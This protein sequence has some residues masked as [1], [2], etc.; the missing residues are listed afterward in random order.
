MI[1]IVSLLAIFLKSCVKS[2]TGC[3]R[4][5]SNYAPRG[6]VPRASARACGA[7]RAQPHSALTG[8]KG[9]RGS[10]RRPVRSGKRRGA[11]PASPAP[12]PLCQQVLLWQCELQAT[13]ILPTPQV[14]LGV[15]ER[16]DRRN[17]WVTP[18]RPQ[19]LLGLYSRST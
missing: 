12:S 11:S 19:E 4:H 3:L 14:P 6:P 7:A 5:G 15:G 16:H 2:V 17:V 13:S 10:L 9:G 18:E 1:L 8:Y